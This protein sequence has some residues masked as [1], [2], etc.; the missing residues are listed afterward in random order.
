MIEATSPRSAPTWH[1][2]TS[3]LP[4]SLEHLLAL[5][6]SIH[7]SWQPHTV[8]IILGNNMRKCGESRTLATNLA[9]SP[10]TYPLTLL[11][12]VGNLLKQAL[13][14]NAD[15]SEQHLNTSTKIIHQITNWPL[16]MGRPRGANLSGKASR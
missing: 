12:L 1:H 11:G 13:D 9:N 6:Q 7:S 14:G 2:P 15:A 8:H 10:K 4:S 5:I 3:T 16:I